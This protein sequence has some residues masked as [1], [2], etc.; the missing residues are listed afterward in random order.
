MRTLLTVAGLIIVGA[1][2]VGAWHVHSST[3]PQEPLKIQW[4]IAHE[5]V[6]L[7]DAPAK[8][9]AADFKR[10]TGREV[11][12]ELLGP[13]D[14]GSDTGTLPRSTVFEAL[15]SGKVQMATIVVSGLAASSSTRQLGVLGLP[16]LFDDAAKTAAVV[17]G[18]IGTGLLKTVSDNTTATALAFTFSGGLMMI[19]SNTK[20]FVT[21]ADFKGA[22]IGTINGKSVSADTLRAFGSVPVELDATKGVTDAANQ[23]QSLDGI[24]TPYTRIATSTPP[25]YVSETGHS[26]FLTSII[27]SDAFNH[28]LEPAEQ[29]ALEA[30]ARVAAAKERADS[31]AL[32]A[33]KRQEL[34]DSGTL[35]T[36][37]PQATIDALKAAAA[38]VY[39]KYAPI[40]GA[41]LIQSI[42]DAQA[43]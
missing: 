35:I 19:E 34:L 15:E 14:F 8:D 32:A 31:L 1:L 30:S 43:Y 24:E 41:D 23:L 18:P 29:T 5:P 12:V 10:R 37:V 20:Q 22:R 40:F 25:K 36:A 38:T 6:S 28:S 2:A 7:F 39:Q 33:E 26:F 4:L 13:K 11:E 17:E 42:K 21:A 27:A 9:F 16:F 3:E